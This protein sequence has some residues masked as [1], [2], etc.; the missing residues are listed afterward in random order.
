MKEQLKQISTKIDRIEKEVTLIAENHIPHIYDRMG[1]MEKT[2][3]RIRTDVKSW[4]WKLWAGV[5]SAIAAILGVSLSI[6]RLLLEI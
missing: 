2:V 1:K 3:K 5:I 6:I 4:S